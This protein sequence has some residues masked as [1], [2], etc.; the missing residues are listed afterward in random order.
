MLGFVWT[1]RW[2]TA[3]TFLLGT[4]IPI[5]LERKRNPLKT[6][7]TLCLLLPFGSVVFRPGIIR[8]PE[9]EG[10]A[11]VV[12]EVDPFQD[13]CMDEPFPGIPLWPHCPCEPE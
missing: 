4:V 6:L 5:S 13:L 3:V 11:C 12:G 8:S 9:E 2:C 7:L 10:R 1:D